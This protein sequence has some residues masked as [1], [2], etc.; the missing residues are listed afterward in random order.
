MH[1][2][3]KMLDLLFWKERK[4]IG[5]HR[6]VSKLAAL[7]NN[8]SSLRWSLVG[9]RKQAIIAQNEFS[10]TAFYSS[11]VIAR[12]WVPQARRRIN[13]GPWRSGQ[14]DHSY[15]SPGLARPRIVWTWTRTQWTGP[16]RALL[17]WAGPCKDG[18]HFGPGPEHKHENDETINNIQVISVD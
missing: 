8:C 18:P 4:Q 1:P 6:W 2:I 3:N 9:C 7:A 15:P 12:V 11:M 5:A 17:T 16:R 13:L 10:E 14:G